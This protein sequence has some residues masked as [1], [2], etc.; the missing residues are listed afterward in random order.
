MKPKEPSERSKAILLVEDEDGLRR[1]LRKFLEASGYVVHEARNGREGLEMCEAHEGPI[2]LLVTDVEMPELDGHE[3]VEG[4]LKVRP[5]LTVIFMSGHP[6]EKIFQNMV[7]KETAFL[8][9]PFTPSMLAQQVR[10]TLPSTAG[11]ASQF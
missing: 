5:D 1:L 7:R 4:A 9:K 8:Q 6:R 3:L 10:E 2:D 11:F